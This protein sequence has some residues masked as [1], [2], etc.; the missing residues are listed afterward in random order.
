MIFFKNVIDKRRYICY[1]MS[2]MKTVLRNT[3]KRG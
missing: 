2:T 1:Y 3:Q